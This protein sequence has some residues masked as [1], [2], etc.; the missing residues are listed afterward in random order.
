LVATGVGSER[1][2][3]AHRSAERDLAVAILTDVSLSTDA[4][5][6]NRRVLDVEKE[7][8]LVLAHGL[9][10]CGDTYAIQTFTS[11]RRDDVR[12]QTI[13]TFDERL[14]DVVQRRIAA[15][16]PVLAPRSDM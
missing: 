11:R 12:I 7:A 2:F 15:L 9:D 16:R 3:E 14:S 13:K 8:L 4:W 6:H 5:V 1:I 10:G